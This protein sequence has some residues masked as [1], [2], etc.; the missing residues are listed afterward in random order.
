VPANP[1]VVLS[2]P[3]LGL[4]PIVNDPGQNGKFKIPT[5]RNVAVT[6][7]YSHNGSFPTLKDMVSFINDRNGFIPGVKDNIVNPELDP[8]LVGNLGLSDAD[9]DDLV[10][11]LNTLTDDY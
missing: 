10:A 6:A 11:F 5:L 3:D 8:D 9:I 2:E 1:L 7:P 4:G